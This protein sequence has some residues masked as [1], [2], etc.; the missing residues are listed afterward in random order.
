MAQR[1]GRLAARDVAE[2]LAAYAAAG[3]APAAPTAA[4]LA[5]RARELVASGGMPPYQAV[6]AAQALA[7]LGDAEPAALLQALDERFAAEPAAPADSAA[8][9]ASAAGLSV[10][11]AE[12]RGSGVAVAAA[13]RGAQRGP[14]A[15]RAAQLAPPELARLLFSFATCGVVPHRLLA[16]GAGAVA[17]ALAAAQPQTTATLLWSLATLGY[18]NDALLSEAA[19]AVAATLTNASPQGFALTLWGYAKL[20]A[21]ARQQAADDADCVAAISSAAV[22]RMPAA[23]DGIAQANGAVSDGVDVLQTPEAPDAAVPATLHEASAGTAA[24]EGSA[25]GATLQ[26]RPQ[27]QLRAEAAAGFLPPSSSSRAAPAA[28]AALGLRSSAMAWAP[29]PRRPLQPQEAAPFA[30]CADEANSARVTARR[31]AAAQKQ[32]QRRQRAPHA[33]DAV[34]AAAAAH[35]A[36][37]P[38][39]LRSVRGHCIPLVL[40]SFAAARYRPATATLR[41]LVHAATERLLELNAHSL[42]MLAASLVRCTLC[43][44]RFEVLKFRN[45]G[46]LPCIC[47]GFMLAASLVGCTLCTQRTAFFQQSRCRGLLRRLYL[48]LG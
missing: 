34:F 19:E 11:Q 22:A 37:C 1:A 35:L 30:A 5:D 31:T 28:A 24:L 46:L 16:G 4:L 15:W 8:A 40:W 12:A 44:H 32:Q 47:R 10:K 43:R 21:A 33:S 29:P 14:Q 2:L 17:A 41:A 36:A 26:G 3:W 48:G 39:L 23:P 27:Q 18:R 25:D 42:S 7:K 9:G 45:R 20:T 38:S 13:A 6:T